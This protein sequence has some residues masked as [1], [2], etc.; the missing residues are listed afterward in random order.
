MSYIVC[1][2]ICVIICKMCDAVKYKI[3]VNMFFYAEIDYMTNTSK[4][5]ATEKVVLFT[6]GLN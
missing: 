2:F 3:I 5:A 6:R 4:T 1:M